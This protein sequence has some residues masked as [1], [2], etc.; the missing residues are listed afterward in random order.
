MWKRAFGIFSSAAWLLAGCG[1]SDMAA[2]ATGQ[3]EQSLLRG[4]A[5]S[6]TGTPS[7]TRPYVVLLRFETADRIAHLCSGSYIAPRVVLTAGHCVPSGF[8]HRA[9]AYWGT[10]YDADVSLLGSALPTPD[11]PSLWANLDSWQVYPDYTTATM[12]ADLA[13]VYL[14]RKPPFDPLPIYRNR[15]DSSWTNQLATLVGWGASKSLTADGT[16]NEGFGVK[17]TGQAPILG[18]PTQ[19][20]YHSDDPNP[21]MLIPS[22]RD[23]YVKLGG[24]APYANHCKGDSGGPI[25]VNKSGQDYIAGVASWSGLWCEDYSLFTRVD[26]YLTFLDEAFRRGGQANLIPSL[27]C[28]DTRANGKLTAY[29]GYKNDNGVTINLP[30]DTNKNYLPLDVTN[31]RPTAFK[32]GDNRFQVG[33]DFTAGQ[34]VYW[35]LSPPNSPITEL[36]ATSSSLRCADNEGSRCAR[37]CEATMAAACIADYHTN[38]Q[39]CVTDCMSGYE[40]TANSGCETQWISYLNCTASTPP[41]AENWSCG[42]NP[43][44]FPRPVACSSQLDAAFAC[45]YPTNG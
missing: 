3:A 7:V 26:P 22:V 33:I 40:S 4:T 25:I 43:A 13:A 28:V 39:S 23:H 20:D 8:I 5:V 27:D 11:Q 44:Q 1:T 41:A 15:L 31:E 12:D 35:K 30:Y 32:P 18:S 34:T 29:F 21:G 17:R 45:L 16:S 2:E 19:A 9:L 36:R 14:D 24:K 37:N 38:W 42:E 10:N 6:S